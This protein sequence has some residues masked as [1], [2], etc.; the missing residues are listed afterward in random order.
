MG[1][2]TRYLTPEDADLLAALMLR[3]EGD[4]PTQFC[5]AAGEIREIMAGQP[6]S[7]FDG[8]FDGGDLVGFTTLLP[9]RPHAAGHR[10]ILFGDVDPARLGQGIGTLMLQRALDAGRR[11]H[12]SVAP[13]VGARYASAALEGRDDQ[14]GLLRSAGFE[15][16]RHSF[17][18]VADLSGPLPAPE[19]PPGL[20]VEPFDPVR[21]DEL[22]LAHNDAFADYPEFTGTGEEFWNTFMVTAAHSRHHLS[23]VARTVSGDVAGYVYPHEY[24]VAPSGGSDREIHIAYV[25]TLPAYRG[26]GLATALL[27][28]V[29]HLS[30]EAGYQVASLNVDTANPTGALGIYERAGFRQRYRQDSYHLDE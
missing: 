9:G 29:L 14:V 13:D 30:Q 7:V 17:F 15:P 8:A 26:R 22:R 27:G 24:A 2:T 28:R 6:D 11:I 20:V 18:M 19:L 5:L 1:I 16:G 10:F 23:A 3:V 25:G 4:H 12:T 21:A